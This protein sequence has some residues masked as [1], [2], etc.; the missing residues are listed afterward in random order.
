MLPS[1]T[2]QLRSVRDRF[3]ETILPALPQDADFAHE[4]A[5]LIAATLDW[6]LDTHE[7]EY[8]YE[9]VENVEYRRLLTELVNMDRSSAEPDMTS[10]DE[11]RAALSRRGPAAD[12]AAIP[13]R[14]LAAQNKQL[15]DIAGRMAAAM[16]ASDDSA[17]A[18]GARSLVSTLARRQ[19]QREAALYR[20]TGFP[21]S[22]QD[23]G[24]ALDREEHQAV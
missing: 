18:G 24:A 17:A 22:K 7:H 11:A 8:R 5:N 6:L 1:I 13:L 15:K 12:E 19:G 10:I 2:Q 23:L 20:M 9:V 21:Q 16:M 14:E 3:T 4:Q